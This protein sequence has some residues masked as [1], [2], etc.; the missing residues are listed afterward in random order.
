MKIG[1]KSPL[2]SCAMSNASGMTKT[3]L[4]LDGQIVADLLKA[5]KS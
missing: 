2:K 1:D 5:G 3:T 4:I